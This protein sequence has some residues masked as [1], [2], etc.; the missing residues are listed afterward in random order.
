MPIR[1]SL[2]FVAVALAFAS[3]AGASETTVRI[4]N[5]DWQA[6]YAAFEN[7]MP[8]A[9]TR[10]LLAPQGHYAPLQLPPPIAGVV[11]LEG[12][13]ASLDLSLI[14]EPSAPASAAQLWH[15]LPGG[16]LTVRSL[17]AHGEPAVP[18]SYEP[19][20]LNAGAV[21]IEAS[22]LSHMR[23]YNSAG[24]LVNAPGARLRLSNVTLSDNTSPCLGRACVAGGRLFH[25]GGSV[26]LEYT[27]IADSSTAHVLGLD[28]RY[29][30][31]GSII[32]HGGATCE[33]AVISF[34][35]NV[36]GNASCG[37]DPADRIAPQ[38]ALGPLADNGGPV[39]SRAL[40]PDSTARGIGVD[41]LAVDARGAQRPAQGCDAGAFQAGGRFGNPNL[42]SGRGIEGVYYAPRKDG[43]YLQVQSIQESVA[44]VTWLT[45]DASGRPVWI[46]SP[47]DTGS[48]SVQGTAYVNAMADDGSLRAEVWGRLSLDWR[49]C[50]R[51]QL[52]FDSE[53]A[54]FES[55]VA[56]LERL[57]GSQDIGCT[58]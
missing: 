53:R 12:A 14:V 32:N 5:G 51:V 3:S 35:G 11:L 2:A 30:V 41:C 16:K 37:D 55:G 8:Q 34:G 17:H 24:M 6:L 49:N 25:N 23:S 45:F 39:P 57:T 43:R 28:G 20:I 10:I 4:E 48:E 27:T 46:Y 19:V 38:M 9:E 50:D 36:F 26:R 18:A 54:G 21:S 58:R 22:T 44:L 56:V 7:A 33:A 29:E 42:A 15:V 1:P 13:G 47:A 40:L 52:T 31:L